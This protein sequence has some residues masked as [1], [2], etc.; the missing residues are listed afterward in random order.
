[1]QGDL[2]WADINNP[3]SF[4]EL[5]TTK[6][7][8]IWCSVTLQCSLLERLFPTELRS[9]IHC[10]NSLSVAWHTAELIFSKWLEPSGMNYHSWSEKKNQGAIKQAPALP[11]WVQ[12]FVMLDDTP[13]WYWTYKKE[14]KLLAYCQKAEEKFLNLPGGPPRAV[15][16]QC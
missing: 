8:Q 10:S 13:G 1:M 3:E 6:A 11:R 7:L 16:W 15:A 5:K 9:D 2:K 4:K 14:N 12:T